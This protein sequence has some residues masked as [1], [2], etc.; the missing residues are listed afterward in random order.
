MIFL[1]NNP[2]REAQTLYLVLSYKT[3]S[4]SESLLFKIAYFWDRF[5]SRSDL[6][7]KRA[8]T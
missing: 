5:T 8:E 4:D 6:G 3:D 1:E 7:R 2:V